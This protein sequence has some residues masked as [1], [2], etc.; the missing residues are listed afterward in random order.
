MKEV[1]K[2]KTKAQAL[3]IKAAVESVL[4]AIEREREKEIIAKRFGLFAR[5]ETLE[6]IGESLNITRERVRQLEKS[7]MA[8]LKFSPHSKLPHMKKVEQVFVKQLKDMGNVARIKDLGARLDDRLNDHIHQSRIA[9]LGALSPKFVLIKADDLHH[10]GIGLADVHDHQ[11]FKSGV[12]DIVRHI[13]ETGEPVTADQ[14]HTNM[15]KHHGTRHAHALATISKKLS[16][17]NQ[18]WGLS[19]WPT[20]NPKNIRDKIFIILRDN[21][22]PM[23]FSKIAETIRKSDFERNQ[24][25]VQAIHNELIKDSRFILVGRG[26]YALQQ[27]GYKKGTVADV[28]YEILEEAGKPLHRDEIV[29]QVLKVRQVKQTTI[30]L[31]LQCKPIFKRLTGG[32]YILDES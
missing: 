16:R 20:V 21:G 12:S 11:A 8:N 14:I 18:H 15:R 1:S 23:H 30:L 24:V 3:D 19:R 31:N 13:A 22:K 29:Q 2:S 25:T 9:F 6:Q 7:I 26:I 17:L 28:I 5:R 10:H 27:W 32:T 4:A